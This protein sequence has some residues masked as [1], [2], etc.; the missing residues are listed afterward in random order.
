MQSFPPEILSLVLSPLIPNHW[1]AEHDHRSQVFTLR[2]VSRAF[3]RVTVDHAFARIDVLANYTQLKSLCVEALALLI[4]E[5]AQLPV[6]TGILFTCISR[7]RRTLSS[8]AA[9]NHQFQHDSETYICGFIDAIIAFLGKQ[10]TIDHLV[11]QTLPEEA[12]FFGSNFEEHDLVFISAVWQ[13]DTELASFLM[14]TDKLNHKGNVF[15]SAFYLAA[16]RGNVSLLHLINPRGNIQVNALCGYYGNALMAGVAGGN[17]EALKTLI[18]WGADVNFLGSLFGRPLSFAVHC[19]RP[20]VVKLLLQ[21][22]ADVLATDVQ[23][24]NAL[25][26][27]ALMSPEKAAAPDSRE[28]VKLL[29]DQDTRTV[30]FIKSKNRALILAAPSGNDSVVEILL[31]HGADAPTGLEGTTPIADAIRFAGNIGVA[32]LLLKHGAKLDR[33]GVIL[34]LDNAIRGNCAEL[35]EFCIQESGYFDSSWDAAHLMLDNALLLGQVDAAKMLL[36]NGVGQ[37]WEARPDI[38]ASVFDKSIFDKL[39]QRGV[40][41]HGKIFEAAFDHKNRFLLRQL[42][43]RG[44]RFAGTND[45]SVNVALSS[46]ILCPSVDLSAAPAVLNRHVTLPSKTV[47]CMFQAATEIRDIF[48]IR[49]LIERYAGFQLCDNLPTLDRLTATTIL[50]ILH[51][52]AETNHKEEAVALLKGEGHETVVIAELLQQGRIELAR[53][54]K[55]PNRKLCHASERLPRVFEFFFKCYG[56]SALLDYDRVFAKVYDVTVLRK[57][58]TYIPKALSGTIYQRMWT[59]RSLKKALSRHNYPMLEFLLDLGIR[60]DL[61]TCLVSLRNKSWSD[62]SSYA[63]YHVGRKNYHVSE[64]MFRLFA[65]RH[66]PR[67]NLFED[68]GKPVIFLRY[69]IDYRIPANLQMMIANGVDVNRPLLRWG[70]ALAF[71]VHRN[72]EDMVRFLLECG[73]DPAPSMVPVEDEEDSPYSASLKAGNKFIPKLIEAALGVGIYIHPR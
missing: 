69:S 1:L 73:A 23:G 47:S 26:T 8:L 14:D 38:I 5:K 37:E 42:L 27:A 46:V 68:E 34:L 72:N 51:S 33:V 4:R 10:D 7:I 21:A 48:N 67:Y 57:A 61:H 3:N 65:A 24:Q 20:E 58:L 60:N 18:D 56:D 63:S 16:Y 40:P 6:S 32:R 35:V 44:V 53:L 9:S 62:A 11:A 49:C 29:L 13:G 30:D 19:G 64:T 45:D 55:D 71:A 43:E 52:A 2:L 70:N 31:Q 41:F 25:M 28:V 50:M 22:G 17:L 39:L 36:E 66:W 59:Q 54:D 15:L 12:A